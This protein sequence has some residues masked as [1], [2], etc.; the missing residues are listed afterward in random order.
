MS[1]YHSQPSSLPQALSRTLLSAILLS[2]ISACSPRQKVNNF[3][4][5]S[6]GEELLIHRV[7]SVEENL[8]LIALW[9]AGSAFKETVIRQNNPQLG[10]TLK[11][12]D[13]VAIPR[14]VLLQSEPLPAAFIESQK[15][16]VVKAKS[17]AKTAASSRS[18]KAT[19]VKSSKKS[20]AVPAKSQPKAPEVKDA[21][22]SAQ[23]A[24]GTQQP[25]EKEASGPSTTQNLET[26]PATESKAEKKESETLEDQL[27]KN[28]LTDK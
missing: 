8:R 26:A 24:S 22:G 19:P 13:F 2:T 4:K 28:L 3:Y 21:A 10:S 6:S 14:D 5:T 9:Y 16:E 7:N 12:G 1:R 15:A 11:V 17:S 18:R 23:P 25:V 20:P 27:L